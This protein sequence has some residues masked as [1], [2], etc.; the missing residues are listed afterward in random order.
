MKYRRQKGMLFVALALLLPLALTSCGGGM[1]TT[2]GGG[3]GGTGVGPVT[4]FGSVKVNGV[5]YA[6]DNANIVIGGVEHRPESE[7]KVGMRVRVRGPFTGTTGAAERIE[8][9]RELRGPMD[10]NGVDNVLNRVRVAGQTILIDPATIFDNVADI[11]ALQTLQA[12]TLR[13]PEVEVH[14]GADDSGFIHAT[15]LRKGAD[16]FPIATDNTEVRGKI[17]GLT[18]VNSR[19]LIGSLQVNYTGASLVNVP[20]TGLANGM[21]VEVKGKLTAAGG[22]GTLNASRIEALDNTVG[23]NSDAVR[24]EGYVVSGTS[25]DS[26]EL[27]GPGGKVSV[28]GR[29]ATL[30]GG[31]VAPGKKV[32]VEG[33]VSGAILRADVVRVRPANSVKIEGVMT[34]PPTPSDNITVLSKT[35]Q[36]DAYTRFKDDVLQLRTFGLSNLSPNDNVQVVG[37]YDGSRVHAIRVERIVPNDPGLV[38][39]QGPLDNGSIVPQVSFDI[40]GIRVTSLANFANTEFKDALGNTVS[41]PTFFSTVLP[42]IQPDQVIKVKRGVFHAGTLGFPSTVRDED[43]TRNMEVEIEQINN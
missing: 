25:K 39:L 33:A 13:H 38:L 15:Y 14:G 34:G 41:M 9:I 6:T 10:D 17:S 36:V 8:V 43:S 37:S 12:G 3:T 32:Q 4:G 18:P 21:Y 42:G 7:L 24:I 29:G 16:D 31:T 26:F 5:E 20:L 28:D 40:V 22:S 19:L 2:A 35:V 23:N 1:G 27:L 30:S 11:L